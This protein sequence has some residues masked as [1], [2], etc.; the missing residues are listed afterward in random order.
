MNCFVKETY[1]TIWHFYHNSHGICFCKMTDENINEYQVLLPEGQEDF[2]AC[3]DDADGIHLLCQNTVGDIL[4]L[5]HFNGQWRKTTLLQP[6]TPSAYKKDFS[7]RLT[8]NCLNAFYC[9][10]YNGKRMLTH[11]IINGEGLPPSVIDCIDGSF[12]TAS[13]NEAI[14]LFYYSESIQS[15]G[16]KKYISSQRVWEEFLPLKVIKNCQNP[17]LYIDADDKMH[18]VYEDNGYIAEYFDGKTADIG[19][20]QNPVMVYQ[21]YDMLIWEGVADNKIYIKRADEQSPTIF[22]PGGFAKPTKMKLR[23]TSKESNINAD[24]CHGN[25]VNGTVRTYGINNFFATAQKPACH[26]N[27]GAGTN[28]DAHIEI[29]KI[30]IQIGQ[31]NNLLQKLQAQIKTEDIEKINR[32]LDEVE[33]AVNKKTKLF[34]LL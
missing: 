6:K 34:N 18:I 7:L 30:K 2:D 13:G 21:N 22:M 9:I 32:R 27:E 28:T 16:T 20:G 5:N 31:I 8:E 24:M 23:Y 14:Y 25:I 10:T 17:F 3:I 11:H 19:M 26:N 1:N 33:Q 12:C 4:Y 15:W 29:Q